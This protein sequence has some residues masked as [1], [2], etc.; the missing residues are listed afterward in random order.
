MASIADVLQNFNK[1]AFIRTDCHIWQFGG[2]MI[3]YI[4]DENR[5][6]INFL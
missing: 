6:N 4:S 3:P 1:K 2:R 5:L